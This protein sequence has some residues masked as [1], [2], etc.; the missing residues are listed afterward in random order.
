MD[1]RGK[2]ILLTG[3]STGI[4]RELAKVLG[5]RGAVLAIAARRRDLL[6]EVAEEIR[7]AGAHRPIP[8]TVDL[9][10]RGQAAQLGR[11]ALGELGAID[12]LINNA[13]ANLHGFPSAVGDCDEGRRLFELNFW[14]HMALINEIVP[15]MR[16]RGSGTVV[17]VT[18]MAYVAPF[19]AVGTYCASKAA[20]AVATQ[21][22]RFELR[23]YGLHV[24]EVIPG[25]VDTPSS[26]E[27]RLLEGGD[28]WIDRAKATTPEKMARAI[29]RA[30]ELEKSRLIYPRRLSLGYELPVLSRAYARN[31]EKYVDPDKTPVRPTGSLT[32]ATSLR[33]R[34]EWQEKR[35]V[36]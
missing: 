24:L 10:E 29:A 23:R 33:I 26:Y 8:L 34:R 12:V 30:I 32:D 6:E 22:L 3:A 16:Q 1:L 2:R 25:A 13:A 17:N 7:A 27:N 31:V 35:R 19:P 21:G 14:S 9:V 20:L 11:A 4:G 36:G 5:E 18:S 28:Q 15:S